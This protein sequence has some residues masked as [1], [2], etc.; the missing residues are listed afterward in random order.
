M[1]L[2]GGCQHNETIP[3]WKRFFPGDE[4][5][6]GVK[7]QQHPDNGDHERHKGKH[8][9]MVLY[10]LDKGDKLEVC[11]VGFTPDGD[12]DEVFWWGPPP[13]WVMEQ[14]QPPPRR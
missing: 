12:I 7:V 11:Q 2:A 9:A 14:L 4:R 6:I 1:T 13:K 10:V 8:P 5:L 3:T